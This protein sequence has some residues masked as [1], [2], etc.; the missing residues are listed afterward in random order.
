MKIITFESAEL[1]F[2]FVNGNFSP[3]VCVCL[4]GS[5]VP[6]RRAGGSVRDAQEELGDVRGQRPVRGLLRGFG[7]GDRQTHRNQVQDLNCPGW[8]IWSQGP[9]DEDL[10]RHGRG[11]GVRGKSIFNGIKNYK[12]D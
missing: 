10:E 1:Q 8:K 9:R 5:L 2:L 11:A 7:L 6:I 12:R 3:R 4:F